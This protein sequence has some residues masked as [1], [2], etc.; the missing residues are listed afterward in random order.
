MGSSWKNV[1]YIGPGEDPLK[2]VSPK[3]DSPKKDP[4]KSKKKEKKQDGNNEGPELLSDL[5]YNKRE[6]LNDG[7]LGA[8]RKIKKKPQ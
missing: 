5:G 1:T 2:K 3:K 6:N 4:P 8:I 7:R